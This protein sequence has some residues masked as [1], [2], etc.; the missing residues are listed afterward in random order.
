MCFGFF[1]ARCMFYVLGFCSYWSIT[2]FRCFI[3]VLKI[4]TEV[5]WTFHSVGN[6]IISVSSSSCSTALL[7]DVFGSSRRFFRLKEE[8]IG[9]PSNINKRGVFSPVRAGKWVLKARILSNG[10]RFAVSDSD[11]ILLKTYSVRPM[12]LNQMSICEIFS[13]RAFPAA[14][15]PAM[16]FSC[17]L[18][19]WQPVGGLSPVRE[20]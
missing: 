11:Q 2:E 8:E 13:A 14:V 12:A 17:F 15:H 1:V 18:R 16:P 3:Y 9:K 6:S 7:F 19:C 20:M 10:W 5:L 4:S